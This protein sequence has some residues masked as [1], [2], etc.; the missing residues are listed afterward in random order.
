MCRPQKWIRMKIKK[1][2]C[3]CPIPMPSHENKGRFVQFRCIPTEFDF[4]V[5][6]LD[7]QRHRG[8]RLYVILK[9]CEPHS[10]E[11]QSVCDFFQHLWSIFNIIHP[12]KSVTRYNCVE[13]RPLCP[14]KHPEPIIHKWIWFMKIFD[15]S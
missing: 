12:T 8:R 9:Q 1:K 15:D 10:N 6:V 3:L 5:I 11:S 14:N 2:V 4:C 7:G 13:Y